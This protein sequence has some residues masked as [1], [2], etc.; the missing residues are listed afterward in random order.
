MNNKYYQNHRIQEKN[1][2]T[3]LN[4]SAVS[5]ALKCDQFF[6]GQQHLFKFKAGLPNSKL[7]DGVLS[8]NKWVAKGRASCGQ[9]LVLWRP[10]HV[11]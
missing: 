8:R 5:L 7:F 10:L 1:I 11:A 9:H 4:G 6:V 3:L 2:I